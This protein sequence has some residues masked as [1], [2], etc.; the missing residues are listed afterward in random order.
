MSYSRDSVWTD[1]E[2]NALRVH[3]PLHGPRWDGWAEVLGR[4]SE[5]SIKSKAR[6]LCLT[7]PRERRERRLAREQR[8]ADL[9]EFDARPTPDPFEGLVLSMLAGGRTP[10]QVDAIMRWVPGR[11]RQILVGRWQRLKEE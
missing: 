8:M 5:A 4:R 7:Q 10:R 1:A 11:A 6:Q 2:V 3:F 9:A